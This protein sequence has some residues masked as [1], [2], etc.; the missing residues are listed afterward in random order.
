M[1]TLLLVTNDASSLSVV[2]KL[3]IDTSVIEVALTQQLLQNPELMKLVDAFYFEHHVR[4]AELSPYWGGSMSG[5]LY[6]SIKLFTDLRRAGIDA[7]S[8]V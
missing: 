4:L 6:G 8:W 3:D 1:V 2:I 5:S 7:H